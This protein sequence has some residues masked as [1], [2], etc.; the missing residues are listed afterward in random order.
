MKDP[1]PVKP[2]LPMIEGTCA[3]LDGSVYSLTAIKKAAY[4]FG[5]CCHIQIE[6]EAED[7]IHVYFSPKTPTVDLSSKIGEYLNEVLDQ[8]LRESIAAQTKD[9]CNLIIAHA[10]SKT[11]L[12]ESELETEEYALDPLH[13]TDL[14]EN[15]NAAQDAK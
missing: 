10:F 13:I 14:A 5:D 3:I 4:R 2:S 7:K 6:K 8:D 11:A 9:L 1:N 15:S 12:I